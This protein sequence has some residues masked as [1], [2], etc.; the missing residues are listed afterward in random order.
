MSQPSTAATLTLP[1]DLPAVL[2]QLA[3]RCDRADADFAYDLAARIRRGDPFAVLR[4]YARVRAVSAQQEGVPAGLAL[5]CDAENARDFARALLADREAVV[6][7]LERTAR[8]W[9]DGA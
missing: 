1:A 3:H 6:E 8:E 4:Y 9:E 2:E 7:A 5:A